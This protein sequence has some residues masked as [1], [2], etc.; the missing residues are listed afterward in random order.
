MFVNQGFFDG[1]RIFVVD[2]V[3]TSMGTK[4]ELLEKIEAEARL[5]GMTFHVA[6][7]GI[8][9]DRE[10]TT[11]VYNEE[12]NVVLGRKGNSAIED[13]VSK[14]GIGVFAVAGIKEVV[15]YL[16]EERIPVFLRGNRVPMDDRKPKTNSTFTWK[17]LWH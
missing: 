11:A 14:S 9:I 17:R 6:G 8:G 2:D 3:A 15:Q 7:I 10:Q 1:C 13:F 12:G 5:K 16:Y 4:Y